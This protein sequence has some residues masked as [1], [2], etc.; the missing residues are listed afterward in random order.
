MITEDFIFE[1]SQTIF[2]YVREN[3]SLTL[4][5]KAAIYDI[6]ESGPSIEEI[7]SIMALIT[8][9]IN[10]TPSNVIQFKNEY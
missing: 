6:L 4:Q 5:E 1:L 9:S 7:S 3:Y 2:Y 10:R 8:E